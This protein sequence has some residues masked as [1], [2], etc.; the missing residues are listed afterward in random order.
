MD[1]SSLSRAPHATQREHA[2]GRGG[3]RRCD[4]TRRDGDVQ[5]AAPAPAPARARTHAARGAEAL[6]VAARSQPLASLR[7]PSAACVARSA[8]SSTVVGGRGGVPVA[9][10]SALPPNG[11]AALALGSPVV[12]WRMHLLADD[13]TSSRSTDGRRSAVGLGGRRRAQRCC[14]GRDGRRRRRGGVG[15]FVEPG[16]LRRAEH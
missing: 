16:E 2:P 7:A 13:G 8:G 11:S 15:G 3:R 5:S 14:I 6:S 12:P 1:R 10:P 9:Q 4:A